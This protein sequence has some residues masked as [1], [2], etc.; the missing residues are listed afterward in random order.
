MRPF[1]VYL[2][3]CAD[4]SY[5]CGQTD[6]LEVRLHQH[7]VGEIGY[8]ATRKPVLLVWQGEF[9]TRDEA[10][11]FERQ[12]KGWSRA[13]KEALIAGDWEQIK[14]LAKSKAFVQAESVQT[15][16]SPSTSSGRT[17]STGSKH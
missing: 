10:V 13:K 12:V 17:G 5:Y 11:R 8:T 2:L 7:G 6:N 15:M 14:L 4:G 1:F 16:K 9:E 3:R